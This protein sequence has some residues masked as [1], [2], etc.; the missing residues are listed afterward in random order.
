MR[1]SCPAGLV[2]K[3][4]P[5][6]CRDDKHPFPQ[7]DLILHVQGHRLG[8]S[9]REEDI[10]LT[11]LLGSLVVLE[12]LDAVRQH[13]PMRRRWADVGGVAQVDARGV[14]VGGVRAAIR[15]PATADVHSSEIGNAAEPK[16]G[17]VLVIKGVPETIGRLRGL[18]LHQ[19][20][21][22]R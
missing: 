10:G 11:V 2:A 5:A 4:V 18:A 14:V 13:M 8:V 3:T 19:R 7:A 20:I 17:V 12:V 1:S 9:I 22:T 6:Q 16:I 15:Q 21:S